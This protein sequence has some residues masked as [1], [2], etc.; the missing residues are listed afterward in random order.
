MFIA[1][2][3]LS[4]QLSPNVPGLGQELMGNVKVRPN[5]YRPATFKILNMGVNSCMNLVNAK[6]SALDIFTPLYPI[7]SKCKRSATLKI[8]NMGVNSCMNTEQ[9]VVN[10]E[11]SAFAQNIF[12]HA[13]LYLEKLAQQ[14]S[15]CCYR[16]K[17]RN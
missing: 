17:I 13:N 9:T 16:S 1:L 10:V 12:M 5:Y 7:Y 8:L 6:T 15:K 4:Y 3:M 11:I 14:I 2:L